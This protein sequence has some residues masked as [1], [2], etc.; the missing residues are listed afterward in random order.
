MW[1]WWGVNTFGYRLLLLAGCFVAATA[2]A[3][4]PPAVVES[5]PDLK[6][7]I[8][9][10]YPRLYALYQHLHSHPEVSLKEEQTAARLAREVR[11]LG[12]E[13]TEKVGG[14]GIV[15]VLKNGTGPTILI[16]TDMDG[17]PVLELTGVPYASRVRMRDKDGKD[18]PT[19][20]ACGHDMHMTCWVTAGVDGVQDRWSGTLVF[21]GQP[22]EEIGRA[23]C[24]C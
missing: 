1:K 24:K 13:V 2:T 11:E 9:A 21:I 8:E 12:F 22:A 6:G 20:H 16:R 7:K 14:H 5:V 18:V 4:E 10:E 23:R 3:K 17:L 19:M 15:G